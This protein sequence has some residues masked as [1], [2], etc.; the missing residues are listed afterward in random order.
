VLAVDEANDVGVS[1]HDRRWRAD[2]PITAHVLRLLRGH[3]KLEH[4]SNPNAN[5]AHLAAESRSDA[6]VRRPSSAA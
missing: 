4:T 2:K 6:L 1:G 5:V 3:L